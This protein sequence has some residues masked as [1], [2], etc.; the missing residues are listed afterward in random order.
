MLGLACVPTV[1]KAEGLLGY[2]FRLAGTNGVSGDEL[3]EA[4]RA[5]AEAEMHPDAPEKQPLIGI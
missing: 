4:Y 5:D 2:L 3:L 1:L